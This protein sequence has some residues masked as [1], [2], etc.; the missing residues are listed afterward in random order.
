MAEEP[1]VIKHQME[2]T[3]ADLTQ[4]LETL[5]HQVVG[6]VQDATSAVSETVQTVKDTVSETV[7][8]VKE[9]V[10]DT[11]DTVRESV[12]ETFDLRLQV[13]RRPWLMFGGSVALGY[14]AGW[15]L[16]KTSS[17]SA[18]LGGMAEGSSSASNWAP[19][20]TGGT[21]DGRT[22]QAATPRTAEPAQ[23]GWLS[24]VADQFQPE[25]NRLK[26]LAIG[27]LAGVVR[28][29]ITRAVPEQMATQL[30]GVM[31][32][33]TTKLGGEPVRGPVMD[34]LFGR[35]SAHGEERTPSY[36]TV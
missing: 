2:E 31:D 35:Q 3:R 7:G 23:P 19:F 16:G 36:P 33:I 25:I 22:G 4:K 11:V 17:V 6:T 29:M 8:S 27:A 10:T 20:T 24:A 5:E 1:D 32:D 13:E 9:A 26:G 12:K 18:N 34:Q 30:T 15:L 28:D 14:L 21:G